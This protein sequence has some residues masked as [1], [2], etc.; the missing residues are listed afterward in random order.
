MTEAF[1][2]VDTLLTLGDIEG[3]SNEYGR[4]RPSLKSSLEGLKLATRIHSKAKNWQKVDVLCRVMRQ[5]FP[6]DISGFSEG[7][8]SFHQ[9]GRN[10]EAINLLKLWIVGAV[11]DAAIERAIARYRTAIAD[12]DRKAGDVAET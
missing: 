11:D 8:E 1:T 7:A 9:Q 10:I 2:A 12:A 4:L 6:M 3:A 5:E